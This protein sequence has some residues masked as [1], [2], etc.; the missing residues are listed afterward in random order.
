MAWLA[1][2]GGPPVGISL[3]GIVSALSFFVPGWHYYR[4]RNRRR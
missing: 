4:S 2:S 3:F 1:H